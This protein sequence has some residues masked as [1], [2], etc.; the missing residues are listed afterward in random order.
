MTPKQQEVFIKNMYEDL[1]RNANVNKVPNYC[2]SDFVEEN[3]YDILNYNTF[4]KH[5]EAI[6]KQDEKAS[7]DIEFTVN[8]PRQV[9]IRTI[10]NLD[11]QIKGAPPISLLIS[12]WQ[13]NKE[14]LVNYCK[15]VEYAK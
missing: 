10:V 6:G 12:Y 3:N 8:V 13:F 7:F 4:I 9:V 5:I 14:G 15:E 2:A 11:N 1:F